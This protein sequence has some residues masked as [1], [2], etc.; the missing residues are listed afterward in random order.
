MKPRL[1]RDHKI[2]SCGFP[3]DSVQYARFDH[4]MRELMDV[5]RW[6]ILIHW[7]LDYEMAIMDLK[8]TP[9]MPWPSPLYEMTKIVIPDKLMID[10]VNKYPVPLKEF[11]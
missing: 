9:P 4:I 3:I 5:N 11:E 6:R 1:S 7:I 10:F 8:P 2:S